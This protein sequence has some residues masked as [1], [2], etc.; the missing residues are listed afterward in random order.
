MYK[1][2]QYINEKLQKHREK[3]IQYWDIT[4]NKTD[5]SWL[6]KYVSVL[7]RLNIDWDV[8][9]KSNQKL[10]KPNH[11]MSERETSIYSQF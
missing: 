6:S 3:M 11:A 9:V 2:T 1:H 7:P 8:V 5:K 4:T 10:N